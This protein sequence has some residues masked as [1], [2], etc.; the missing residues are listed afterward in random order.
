MLAGRG[1]LA[2]QR[3]ARDEHVRRDHSGHH[4]RQHPAGVW[5]GARGSSERR[6][7]R[8]LV[9]DRSPAPREPRAFRPSGRAQ[10]EFRVNPWSEIAA[11][12]KR[13]VGGPHAVHDGDR[14]FATSGSW[15]RC[16]SMNLLLFGARSAWAS[17]ARQ[18]AQHATPAWPSASG[19]QPG[20]R[21]S[22]GRQG[23]TG[24]GAAGLRSAWVRQPWRCRLCSSY[25]VVLFW[26][27]LLGFSGGLFVVPSER[28]PAAE[29][30]DSGR[31]GGV[32][33]DKQRRQ[34]DRHAARGL[35]R[36]LVL[37]RIC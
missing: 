5:A 17:P 23:G 35:R 32:L 11:G 29:K 12:L 19:R 28:A 22:L 27:S 31:K 10:P 7:S 33:A 9:A 37:R 13:P 21:A 14:H 26:L 15:A 30:P 24:P 34:H 1:T 2:R 20:G 25:A 3:P 8:W 36:A 18:P 16:S 6:C 4:R